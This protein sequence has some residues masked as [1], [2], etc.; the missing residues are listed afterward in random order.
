MSND[1]SSVNI[2]QLDEQNI[3]EG[4]TLNG[5]SSSDLL[6]NEIAIKQLIN[7]HNLKINEVKR[8]QNEISDLKSDLEFQKT[9]PY[10]ASFS[11]LANIVG[12]IIIGYGVNIISSGSSSTNPAAPYVLLISGGVLIL[13][14]GLCTIFYR[15]ARK[16]FNGGDN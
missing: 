5:I 2:P 1:N 9:S 15:Y 14:G 3:Y 8:Y 16:W 10:I 12:T 7:N 11:L 13:G 6:N 4:G